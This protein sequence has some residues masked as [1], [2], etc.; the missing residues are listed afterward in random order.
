MN[1]NCGK[2]EKKE[3]YLKCKNGGWAMTTFHLLNQ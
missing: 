1:D 3:K 2:Q